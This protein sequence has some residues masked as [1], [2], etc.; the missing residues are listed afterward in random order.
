MVKTLL[1]N[2]LKEDY[3]NNIN[4]GEIISKLSSLVEK[5]DIY[6]NVQVKRRSVHVNGYCG[7]ELNFGNDCCIGHPAKT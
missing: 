5:Y 4:D 2:R 6:F 7:T 3:I 1:L